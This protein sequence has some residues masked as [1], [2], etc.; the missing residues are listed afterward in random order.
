[1]V[2]PAWVSRES[3]Q[4]SLYPA[5]PQVHSGFWGPDE[6]VSWKAGAGAGPDLGFPRT[7][8]EPPGWGQCEGHPQQ[9]P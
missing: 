1:M 2:G 9:A 6:T 5:A 7:E 4:R 3:S 8:Q